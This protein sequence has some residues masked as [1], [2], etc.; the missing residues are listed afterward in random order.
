MEIELKENYD[1]AHLTTMGVPVKARWYG[2]YTNW[3]E[4]LKLSRDER[5]AEG[6]IL[7][8]GGGSNLL[9]LSD[10]DGVVLR[11]RIMGLHRYD[12]NEETSYVMAGAGENWAE[13]VDWTIDQE[14]AGLENLA[15][16]P[17]NVGAA[18]VQNVGAY[19]AEAKDVIH[20]V[21]CF[22]MQTRT[23][24]LFTAAECRFGYRDSIFKHEGRGRFV[25]LRVSFKLKRS[26]LAT[27]LNYTPL[28]DFAR[29][30]GRTPTIRVLASEV[31]RIRAA[32]L[33][34]PKEMGSVGSFFKNPVV[35]NKYI[36]EVKAMTG[37]ELSGHPAG[38]HRTKLSAAWLIDHAGMKGAS[39]GGAQ[40]YEKQPLVIVN[41]GHA[42]GID[43]AALAENI[44]AAVREKFMIDLRPE[45]NYIDTRIQVEILGSGTSKGIPEIGCRCPVCRSTDPKDN[46]LRASALVRTMGM[47]LL[48]DPGPDF[49]QQALRAG[50]DHIDAVLVTHV[51]YDHVGGLDDLRPFCLDY[52]LPL[53]CNQET[54]TELHRHYDYCFAKNPY[55][56]VPTFDLKVVG[57]TSFNINGLKITPVEVLHG[58]K[59]ILGYRIGKFAYLTDVKSIDENELDK[60]KDLDLLVLNALRQRPHF[61]H[62]TVREAL[63]LISEI[64]PKRTL[65]THFNHE[66]GFHKEFA[67][68]LPP[69]VEPAYDGQQIIIGY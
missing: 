3:K 37:Y 21:E 24:R 51:H 15:G 30:L 32:K 43:V 44:R 63:D 23:V 22:D 41:T 26:D 34:D 1:I 42:T 19:G 27:N 59:Q 29:T 68:T 2:E 49:R 14:L 52:H 66:I 13:V 53:Y 31:K 58:T 57:N 39:C 20:T 33:P 50:V 25:V 64:H 16:I 35:H 38:A 67:A 55:P 6:N 18:P 5:I 4:L 60:L 9:F 69:G 11:S 10:F 48:I 45:A 56:G 8:L 65:L 17:G 40:V 7:H 62:L 54:A 28:R 61:A 46:R 36:E 12:K 47:T